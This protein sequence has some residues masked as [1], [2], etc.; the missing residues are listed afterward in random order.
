MLCFCCLSPL[1]RPFRVVLLLPVSSKA[2]PFR[3]VGSSG[4]TCAEWCSSRSSGHGEDTRDL[5]TVLQFSSRHPFC[6]T[7][8]HAS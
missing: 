2:V 4:R 8:T 1:R 3:A 5:L 6:V 7:M